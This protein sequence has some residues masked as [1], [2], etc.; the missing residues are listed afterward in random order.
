[1]VATKTLALTGIDLLN[2][3]SQ[4]QKAKDDYQK[5]IGPD[6]IYSALIG[7]R[8]PALDYRD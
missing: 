8:K 4:I 6:F 1:M 7:N 2:D 5:R 3:S